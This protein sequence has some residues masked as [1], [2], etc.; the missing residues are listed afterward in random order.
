MRIVFSPESYNLG[1]TTRCIEVANAAREAGH[2][3]IF[4][5][6]SERYVGL[7]RDAGHP[8]RLGSPVMTDRQARQVMA[9]DQGRGISHPFTLDTV[10]RRVSGELAVLRDA[11]A[12]VVGSNPTM[13]ISARAAGVP[14]FYVRPYFMSR[15]YFLNVD[16]PFRAPAPLRWAARRITWKPRSFARVAAEHGVT[17][18]Q[19]LVDA[20]TGD[21]DLIASLPPALDARPLS[22]RD[23]AIGPVHYR[24]PDPLPECL[25]EDALHPLVYV[26]FGS[27]GSPS[28]LAK[29]LR[30][31]DTTGVNIL[32]GGGVELPEDVLAG[33]SDRVHR[34]GFVPEHRLRHRIDAAFIHGGEGTVQAICLSGV[35]FAGL[36][37]QAEQRWNLNE[38][39]R[40]GNA[41]RMRRSDITRGRVA[42]ILR[43]L[44]E[45][46]QMRRQ[47]AELSDRMAE[48]DG[49]ARAVSVIERA[50]AEGITT[51]DN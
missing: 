4:H 15:S 2:D 35:P 14:L 48:L 39:V 31:L 29:T 40:L 49:P 19:P 8:V 16:D 27:S 34:P 44:L 28:L 18:P 17:L 32:V 42:G 9:L 51:G 46:E 1:E 33:L 24:A 13:F 12:A 25:D 10:R 6:Y 41:V 45:D 23:V 7:I 26:S 38:C 43:R 3:V 20:M 30:Q 36:P 11:D 47:A 22:S 5:A 50:V 37:M 21:V